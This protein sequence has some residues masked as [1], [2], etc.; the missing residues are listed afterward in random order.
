MATHKAPTMSERKRRAISSNAQ[1]SQM[2][3]RESSNLEKRTSESSGGGAIPGG[4]EDSSVLANMN[5]TEPVKDPWDAR[6]NYMEFSDGPTLRPVLTHKECELDFGQNTKVVECM[7]TR[8]VDKKGGNTLGKSSSAEILDVLGHFRKECPFRKPKVTNVKKSGGS[9][10][11]SN[12]H[13]SR[14]QVP[15]WLSIRPPEVKCAVFEKM[16]HTQSSC[17]L[18][19]DIK[20]Q[21]MDPTGPEVGPLQNS[22]H[23]VALRQ[24]AVFERL[25]RSS[26]RKVMAKTKTVRQNPKVIART[27]MVFLA[28]RSV[29]KF[30]GNLCSVDRG[31]ME[32]YF[33]WQFMEA[34]FL[35]WYCLIGYDWLIDLLKMIVLG[36]GALGLKNPKPLGDIVWP[37]ISHRR[38]TR[39]PWHWQR[40]M[41]SI[42]F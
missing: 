16:G 22:G 27:S 21:Q 31:Y 13:V 6:A 32:A 24:S 35:S 4:P 14:G 40:T 38:K 28:Y 29:T 39:E 23:S 25:N 7:K 19:R 15:S 30:L 33:S 36:P 34:L 18:W 2:T 11:L 3:I 26:E 41:N 9:H 8:F 10:T 42:L 37:P 20:N 5:R 1:E 12:F 17:S